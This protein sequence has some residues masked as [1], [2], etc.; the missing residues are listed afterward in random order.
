[1]DFV[2]NIVSQSLFF[3]AVS[4]PMCINCVNGGY[5]WAMRRLCFLMVNVLK[6]LNKKYVATQLATVYTLGVWQP[7]I[8]EFFKILLVYWSHLGYFLILY[9]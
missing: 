6:S 1:M 8:F 4:I 7:I 2:V 3:F 5:F 9:V